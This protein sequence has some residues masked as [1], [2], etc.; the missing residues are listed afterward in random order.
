MWEQDFKPYWASHSEKKVVLQNQFI[1]PYESTKL[2]KVLN[3][4]A[5]L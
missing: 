2:S 3:D 1:V 4:I 5:D